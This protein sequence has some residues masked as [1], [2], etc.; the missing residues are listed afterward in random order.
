MSELRVGRLN[1][2]NGICES[3]ERKKA[4]VHVE[5]QKRRGIR[6]RGRQRPPLLKLSE[7]SGQIGMSSNTG[8]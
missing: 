8:K 1:A 2:G 5:E 4:F 7:P 6:G 3:S